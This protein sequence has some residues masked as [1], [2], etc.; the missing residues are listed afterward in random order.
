MKEKVNI[1]EISYSSGKVKIVGIG[2]VAMGKDGEVLVAISLG[3][4]VAVVIY[5][6]KRK[7]AGMAHVMLPSRSKEEIPLE[8]IGR[9]ADTAVSFIVSSLLGMGSKISDLRAKIA[10][11]ACMFKFIQD[12]RP[13][14]ERNVESVKRELRRWNIPIMGEDVLGDYGRSVEFYV[15][16][17]RMVVKTKYGRRVIR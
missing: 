3:S 5:D 7:I 11:G 17:F 8:R 2:E 1:S 6:E 14:G 9:Y 16:D 12:I 13:I 4:C 10:G 15:G